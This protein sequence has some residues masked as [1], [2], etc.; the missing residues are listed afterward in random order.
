MA[1]KRRK[2]RKPSRRRQFKGSPQGALAKALNHPIR[3]QALRILRDRTAS[4]SELSKQL[5]TPLSNVSY[6]VRVLS[7]LGFVEIVE[8]QDVRGSVAHFYKAVDRQVFDS[9]VWARLDPIVRAA[10]CG[11]V[12]EALLADAAASSA[13]GYFDKRRSHRASRNCLVLDEQGWR[14]VV[15]IQTDALD[16]ILKEQSASAERI[17]TSGA[18]ASRASLAMFFFEIPP[19]A[20][21]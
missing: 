12:I 18:E 13:A 8:E 2:A 4:P 1:R 21:Q 11:E 9:S 6:H 3:A 15:R 20:G 16:R 14:A 17:R 10:V 5:D 7:E 19:D